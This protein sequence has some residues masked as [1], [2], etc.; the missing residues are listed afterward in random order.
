MSLGCILTYR[1]FVSYLSARAPAREAPQSR[2]AGDAA[3]VSCLRCRDELCGS[4]VPN[5][6]KKPTRL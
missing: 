2:L 6:G 3:Q 5:T 1:V 4:L